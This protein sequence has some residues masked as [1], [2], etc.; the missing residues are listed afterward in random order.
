MVTAV[1]FFWSFFPVFAV[2]FGSVFRSQRSVA[3][4]RKWSWF[5]T[6]DER[7]RKRYGEVQGQY[8]FVEAYIHE[9]KYITH[10][11]FQESDLSIHLVEVSDS[12]ILEQE[13]TLCCKPS[14]FIDGNPHIRFNTT[15]GG[16][17][18]YWYRSITEIPEKVNYCWPCLPFFFVFIW[19][20]V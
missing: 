15:K 7:C 16:I 9:S 20:E 6:V 4:S 17:P 3:A 10:I 19:R 1:E 11:Y 8:Y 5:R 18:V 13:K 14:E 12:L 2:Q